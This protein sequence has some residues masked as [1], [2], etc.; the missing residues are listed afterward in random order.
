MCGVRREKIGFVFNKY[1]AEFV[2]NKRGSGES[3]LNKRGSVKF[4]F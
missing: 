2:F 3:A 1:G 4:V